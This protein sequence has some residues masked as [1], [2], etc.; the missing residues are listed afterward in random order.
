MRTSLNPSSCCELHLSLGAGAGLAGR[1]APAAA[2]VSG[3]GAR[4]VAGRA[5]TSAVT[6][7]VPPAAAARPATRAR[8]AVL[9]AGT[10]ILAARTAGGPR[11][12]AAA[13]RPALVLGNQLYPFAVQLRPVQ[14][15]QRVLHVRPR[16]ELHDSLSAA[17]VVGVGV[18]DLAGLTHVVLQIL[19]GGPAGEVLHVYLVAG[20]AAGRRGAPTT[21]PPVATAVAAP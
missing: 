3:L 7:A 11:A 14:L 10:A 20:A 5:V 18:G 19:P 4:L 9:A 13:Q 8:A 17:D 6:A 16:S 15:V 2:A 21:A 12:A 1:A